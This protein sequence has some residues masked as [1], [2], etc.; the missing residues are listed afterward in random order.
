M[1]T[2]I[3][4][5]KWDNVGASDASD[6]EE[7]VERLI[8]VPDVKQ[9]DAKKLHDLDQLISRP[10]P[11]P[12]PPPSPPEQPSPPEAAQE[13]VHIP[14]GIQLDMAKLDEEER[15]RQRGGL[16]RRRPSKSTQELEAVGTYLAD[17]SFFKGFIDEKDAPPDPKAA[18]R[19]ASDDTT[20]QKE[21]KEAEE[22]YATAKA[23]CD[24]IKPVFTP[25]TDEEDAQVDL[26]IYTWQG[27]LRWTWFL[28]LFVVITGWR[29]YD[30]YDHDAEPGSGPPAHRCSCLGVAS[31][32]RPADLLLQRKAFL[33]EPPEKREEGCGAAR[34]LDPSFPARLL[35][36]TLERSIDT[37]EC[38]ASRFE[39]LAAGAKAAPLLPTVQTEYVG[40]Q[41]H[42]GPILHALV[43][44]MWH[45]GLPPNTTRRTRLIAPQL[46]GLLSS[47]GTP[48]AKRKA[49]WSGAD[50]TTSLGEYLYTLST[51]SPD[52]CALIAK[53]MPPAKQLPPQTLRVRRDATT[54]SRYEYS[55]HREGA[56]PTEWAAHKL[57][58]PTHGRLLPASW[59]LF[60]LVSHTL[61]HLIL[62]DPSPELRQ[63]V[64]M[65]ARLLGLKDPWRDGDADDK[66]TID[67]P[68]LGVH[69]RRAEPCSPYIVLG[70]KRTCDPLESYVPHVMR[71]S[72]QYGYKSIYLV[73]DSM[74]VLDNA[75]KAFAPLK[76]LIRPDA[77]AAARRAHLARIADAKAVAAAKLK[78]MQRFSKGRGRAIS[79]LNNT[80]SSEDGEQH[81][82]SA[83]DGKERVLDLLVDVILLGMSC[84]GLVGKFSSHLSRI[85]YSLMSTR[86]SIDCLKPYVSLDIPWCFGLGCRKE[87]DEKLKAA[88]RAQKRRAK[89]AVGTNKEQTVAPP[90]PRP[91]DAATVAKQEAFKRMVRERTPKKWG[92]V[93]GFT[94][95]AGAELA[96]RVRARH[97]A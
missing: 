32:S 2:P 97:Q 86:H 50:A 54:P 73:S 55:E 8:K 71:L 7:L 46:N 22:D 72:A 47:S 33:P 81:E 49:F 61:S 65:H 36:E 89:R 23:F 16:H 24:L 30:R 96:R 45:V 18:F 67:A 52:S 63:R 20:T 5:S 78:R 12:P 60:W 57:T 11:P 66:V 87:G 62:S 38:E 74:S 69:V 53:Y 35:R 59:G 80:F 10:P 41:S 42:L 9:L 3:N 95:E 77:R 84:D 79:M 21:E 82:A 31:D 19:P 25:E 48:A 91:P 64:S 88:W 58:L 4:Y 40:R 15:Q 27:R 56:L 43:P 70:R 14:V 1:A 51:A 17:S 83:D 93:G 92:Y 94:D 75:T 90:P 68:I 6:D 34:S 76:V 13:L 26:S 29:P 44:V 39:R 37:S 85:A 28:F